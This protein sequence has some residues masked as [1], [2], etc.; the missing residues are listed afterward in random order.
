MF[1]QTTPDK[2]DLLQ[3]TVFF[4]VDHTLTRR[5]TGLRFLQTGLKEGYFSVFILATFPYYFFRY[6]MGKL[7]HQHLSKPIPQLQGVPNKTLYRLG[8]D[9]FDHYVKNDLFPEGIRTITAEKEKGKRIVL[10]TSSIDFIVKPIADY[11]QIEYIATEFAFEDELCTGSLKE[12]PLLGDNKRRK[13][14]Q[15]CQNRGINLA[16]CS[17]YSDSI[18]DYPLL[19]QVGTPVVVNPDRRLRK[20]ARSNSWTLL[21]YRK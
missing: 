13:V 5:S 1:P 7:T 15:W 19:N 3:Q 4:D 10:A 12:Y 14:T 20:I 2:V 11:L 16:E 8:Q 9:C 21:R 18:N 17:F 6:R